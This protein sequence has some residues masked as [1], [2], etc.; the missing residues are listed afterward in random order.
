MAH[1]RSLGVSSW[2]WQV[3][4]VPAAC[5]RAGRRLRGWPR[6]IGGEADA[7]TP[8]SLHDEQV[9]SDDAVPAAKLNAVVTIPSPDDSLWRHARVVSEFYN[10]NHAAFEHAARMASQMQ[11]YLEQMAPVMET[12]QRMQQ[13]MNLHAILARQQAAFTAMAIPVPTDD[14]LAEAQD[15]ISELV[16]ETDD[17]REQVAQQAAEIQADPQGKKLIKQLTDWVSGVV[18]SVPEATAKHR[19]TIGLLVLAWL[20][21]FVVPSESEFNRMLLF[22]AAAAAWMMR[23]PPESGQ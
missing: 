8:G 13:D 9:L 21:Q 7:Q 15:R 11:R 17:A 2:S 4:A 22:C 12:V 6:A 3:S 1:T 5:R 20:C 10:A 18:S 19:T 23:F 16:P 14:E